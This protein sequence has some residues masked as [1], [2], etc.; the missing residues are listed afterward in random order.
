MS[1][2]FSIFS[3]IGGYNIYLKMAIIEECD[4]KDSVWEALKKEFTN[5]FEKHTESYSGAELIDSSCG[6]LIFDVVLNFR[7]EV[8]EHDS[9]SLIQNAIVDGKLGELSVWYII[10]TPAPGIPMTTFFPKYHISS[11]IASI[12]LVVLG[13]VGFDELCWRRRGRNSR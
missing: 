12:V 6:S 5:V 8:A 7:T 10:G 1:S 13:I 9:I 3:G 4:K 2:T 11:V